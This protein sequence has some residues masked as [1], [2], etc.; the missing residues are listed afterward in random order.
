MVCGGFG[1]PLRGG[2]VSEVY[3]VTSGDV[4]ALFAANNIA[5]AV[6]NN[7]SSGARLGGLIVN[8]LAADGAVGTELLEDFAGRLSTR[9]VGTVPADALHSRAAREG[10]T[11]VERYPDSAAGAAFRE[12]FAAVRDTTSDDLVVPTPMGDVDLLRFL[13]DIEF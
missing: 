12:L 7:Q 5:R 13:R 2:R 11:A 9:V 1:V 10:G 3:I 4:A 6:T 8:R